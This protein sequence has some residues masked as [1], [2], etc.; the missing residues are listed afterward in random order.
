MIITMVAR[1]R[2]GL[3][4]EVM[5]MAFGIAPPRPR[6]VRNRIKSSMLTSLT[7]AVAS[8]PMPKASVEKI[9]I[10]LRPTRSASG[11]NTSAPI[12][13]PNRPAREHRTQRAL[14]QAPFLGERRRDIADRLGVEA[15]EKQH[16]RAGQEQLELKR[17][18]RLLV[19]EFGDV[20]RAAALS[21]RYRHDCPSPVDVIPGCDAQH[22]T[23]NLEI[24]R[25][26]IAHHSS[27]LRIAPE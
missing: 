2:R 10:F 8:A 26:A 18:D 23:R 20:D 24:L 16:R 19:D 13:S 25:C 22:Q 6:P 17:A 14:G 21:L 9:T 15:V 1:R 27:M 11:P 5:A 4:S 3:N 7:K 12:I